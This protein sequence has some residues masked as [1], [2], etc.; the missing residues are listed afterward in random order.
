MWVIDL[1]LRVAVYCAI[2]LHKSNGLWIIA[3]PTSL[4][5]STLHTHQ[6]HQLFTR[7][8]N[9][10]ATSRPPTPRCG[11]S[12]PACTWTGTRRTRPRY[13]CIYVCE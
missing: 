11:S 9:A 12:A 1:G 3:H 10:P 2:A 8:W 4:S 7:C 6:Q 13:A 5:P